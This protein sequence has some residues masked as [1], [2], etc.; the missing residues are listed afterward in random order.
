MFSGNE[1]RWT[2]EARNHFLEEANTGSRFLEEVDVES[3]KPFSRRGRHRKPE[4]IFWKRQMLESGSRFLEEVD[5]KSRKPF[6]RRDRH[7]KPE[8]IFWK[9]QTPEAGSHF[10]AMQT[11]DDAGE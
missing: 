11:G 4:V 5:A 2:L 6:S 9:R 8:A 10:L 1:N 3:R 7:R